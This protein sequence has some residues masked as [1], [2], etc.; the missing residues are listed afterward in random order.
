MINNNFLD[1]NDIKR[2]TRNMFVR[3]NILIRLFCCCQVIALLF[4]A[5][6]MCMCDAS[7]LW[8]YPITVYNKFRSSYNRCVKMF[9][10]LGKQLSLCSNSFTL[11]YHVW[12]NCFIFFC[13]FFL[14]M[15][16]Y[17]SSVLL[18]CFIS[19]F[20][21]AEWLTHSTATLKVMGSRPS[22]GDISEIY[23]LKSIQSLAQRY[24]KWSV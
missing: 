4:K 21:V 7:I 16:W 11:W 2:E 8:H 5:F 22:F 17:H 12:T 10:F 13:F 14:L 19:R 24:L 20:T 1:N 9:P 23:F 18:I 6:C 3:C 15:L